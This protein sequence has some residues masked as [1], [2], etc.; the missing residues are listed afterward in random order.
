MFLVSQ[1]RP[2]GACHCVPAICPYCLWRSTGGTAPT[3]PGPAARYGEL[4]ICLYLLPVAQPCSESA[5]SYSQL[6]V[7]LC[8]SSVLSSVLVAQ[9]SSKLARPERPVLVSHCERAIYQRCPRLCLWRS[10]APTQPGPA[11][12]CSSLCAGNLSLLL[13]AQHCSESARS[14]R[15]VLVSVIVQSFSTVLGAGGAKQLQLCPIRTTS[16]WQSL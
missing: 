8:D 12:R 1:V 4:A 11:A 5:L 6:L 7:K 14:D 3:R 9:N 2:P 10:T 15:L 16:A 13:V